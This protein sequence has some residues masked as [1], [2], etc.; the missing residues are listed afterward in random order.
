V[1]RTRILPT[2]GANWQCPSS[3]RA[4]AR[5]GRCGW[6]DRMLLSGRI[7]WL[8]LPESTNLKRFADSFSN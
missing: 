8:A 4:L 3:D 5:T 7:L 1:H 6:N 2:D